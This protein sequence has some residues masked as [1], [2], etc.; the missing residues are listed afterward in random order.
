MD[1]ITENTDFPPMAA[2]GLGKPSPTSALTVN[3]LRKEE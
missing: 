3:H 1:S 2:Q